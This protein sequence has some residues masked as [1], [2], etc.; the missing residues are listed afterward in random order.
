MRNGWIWNEDHED[1]FVKIN[2]KIKRVVEL[3]HLKE[4]KKYEL[5]ATRADK[6]YF[7]QQ[8][9]PNG[10]WKPI[11]FAFR[12]LTDFETKFS[13][14]VLELL[15]I[16]L[17]VEHFK[18]YVYGVQFKILSDHKALMSVLKPNG[19]QNFLQQTNTLGR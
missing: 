16:V 12:F 7:Y 15:A 3:S 8:N 6:V 2:A 18:T 4:T 14:N 13:R 1:V 11:C 10:E 17:A 9:Q 19:K 5:C